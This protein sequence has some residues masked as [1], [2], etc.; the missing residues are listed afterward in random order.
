M[1]KLGAV[2]EE[3]GGAE[4]GDA[5]RTARL[6]KLAASIGADPAASF[7]ELLTEAELE[8]AYRFFSNDAVKAEAVIRPH[9]EATLRRMASAE[10]SLVVHD[11]STMS[12]PSDGHR[13]GLS[14]STG[15]H[16]HF[17][18]HVSLAVAADGSRR[19]HGVLDVSHHAMTLVKQGQSQSSRG[20]LQDRWVDQAE[21]VTR[22]HGSAQRLVHVMDREA[23]DYDLLAWMQRNQ[24]RFVVRSHYDRAL[25]E[26]GRMSDRIPSVVALAER[27]VRVSSRGGVERGSKQSRIHPNRDERDAKLKISG[28]AIVIKRTTAA[29]ASEP[30][31]TLNLVVVREV[32][33]PDPK[34]A[35]EWLLLT[36]EPIE[37]EKQLLQII[38]WYRTRWVIEELFKALKT[39]CAF[40]KRQLGSIHALKN[41]LAML[42]PI[43]WR[44]LLLRTEARSAPDS[45]ATAVL[46]RDELAVLREAARRPMPE[47]PTVRDALLAIAGIGGH[48]R[49]NGEPGWQVLG[50]GFERLEDLVT[51]WKIARASRKASRSKRPG[52]DQS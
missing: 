13:E 42:L 20:A 30:D 10:T 28:T 17:L 34:S 44:L 38:D 29:T 1:A 33:P 45:P 48:L 23:D 5:R 3:F 49:R 35:I 14:Q 9:R 51:G 43:A 41:A 6:I 19:A 4:L 36:S 37:T 39:G 32:E 46:S 50:R 18:A 40:E 24:A 15:G 16:Q 8:G 26:G 2:D 52:S 31:I 7:P 12:F 11:S 47:H 21:R 27:S 22:L 25:K